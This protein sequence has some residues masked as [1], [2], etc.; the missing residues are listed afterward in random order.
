[1]HNVIEKVLL[2][3]RIIITQTHT[4]MHTH[5]LILNEL[6]GVLSAW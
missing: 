1:M 2:L 3:K 5:V 4:H 6:E